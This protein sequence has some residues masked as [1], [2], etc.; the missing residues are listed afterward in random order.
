MITGHK[1]TAVR[2]SAK[3]ELF[4]RKRDCQIPLLSSHRKTAQG[5]RGK[6]PFAYGYCGFLRVCSHCSGEGCVRTRSNHRRRRRRNDPQTVRI[7]AVRIHVSC[8]CWAS[9]R[10][11]APLSYVSPCSQKARQRL[12][13]THAARWIYA[14]ICEFIQQLW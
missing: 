7:P 13:H 8:C 5:A 10:R 11:F 4:L 2:S 9:R 1:A 14:Q 3:R 6:L 12:S